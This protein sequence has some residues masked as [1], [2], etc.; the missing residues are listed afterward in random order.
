VVD[1]KT[2]VSSINLLVEK[3]ELIDFKPLLSLS[4]FVQVD[5]LRHV[6]F[7][8]LQSNINISDR[9]VTIPKTTIR[10][11]ALNLEAWGTHSFDNQIDYHIQLLISELLAKKRK[12]KDSEFGPVANDPENRRMAHIRM[13]GPIDD[14]TITY[15]RQG[16]KAKIAADI[17]SEKQTLRR[18]L[19]EELGL[20]KKDTVSYRQRP[21]EHGFKLEEEKKPAPK[22]TLEVK[23]RPQDEE[24]F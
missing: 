16:L 4:R 10:N 13:K 14:P 20:F 12:N 2:I 7:Q 6:R 5:E 8:D 24:D 11:S 19:K 15:D 3:G 22:K 1:E 9:V 17:K 18:V 21:E 23:K